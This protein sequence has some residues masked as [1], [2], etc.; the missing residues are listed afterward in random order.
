MRVP[1]AKALDYL[2]SPAG[3]RALAPLRAE[4]NNSGTNEAQFDIAIPLLPGEEDTYKPTRITLPS[5]PFSRATL[6]WL[7]ERQLHGADAH[8][9]LPQAILSVVAASTTDNSLC[10]AAVASQFGS[11]A[12]FLVDAAGRSNVTAQRSTVKY[13]QL[14]PDITRRVVESKSFDFTPRMP[15]LKAVENAAPPSAFSGWQMA[16]VQHLLPSTLH[17]YELFERLGLINQ[18]TGVLGKPYSTHEDTYRMMQVRGYAMR[19]ESRRASSRQ[20][21]EAVRNEAPPEAWR[22]ELKADIEHHG[23]YE[24]AIAARRLKLADSGEQTKAAAKAMLSRLF[25][26]LDPA[27]E[28]QPRFLLLDDGG[29]LVL[30]LH[31]YFP[32][33]A[34]L[35]VGV[36]QTDRGIQILEKIELR[37]PVI[38][39]ARSEAKKRFESP[40][41]GEIVIHSALAQ[42]LQANPSLQLQ[43]KQAT[44]IGYGAVGRASADALRRRGF[45]V[46]VF[47]IDPAKMKQAED[48]G[49]EAVPRDE[50][51]KQAHLLVSA[52]GRTT[53]ELSEYEALPDGA[54]LV[55]AASGNH[56]LGTNK[57]TT[58]GFFSPF[59]P[60][61]R[62]NKN[63]LAWQQFRG[64]MI[65]LGDHYADDDMMHQV[66]VTPSGKRQLLLRSGNVVNLGFGLPPEFVQLTLGLLAES[67]LQATTAPKTTGLVDLDHTRQ[68]RVIAGTKDHLAEQALALETPDFRHL[69]SWSV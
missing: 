26:G 8:A 62:I 5:D 56:E 52:T 36:E 9:C 55:N 43:E 10:S 67:C 42:L 60:T 69:A 53:I 15:V 13:Q 48:D 63:G 28:T 40:A 61:L 65:F 66:V 29:K 37:C 4:L 7:F 24:K 47:D 17:M 45:L 34:H 38:N 31:E 33:F 41:I 1:L 49:C 57:P 27:N 2:Y 19:P 51:L 23:S 68:D 58:L 32:E 50:A 30:A 64:Q 35:C 11:Q 20:E 59:D 25:A 39:M 21:Q 6:Q 16:S 3:D 46:R 14:E 54:V 22:A 12:G 18:Q 44:V